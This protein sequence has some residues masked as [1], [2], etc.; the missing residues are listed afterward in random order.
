VNI[1]P[2]HIKTS[3]K[4]LGV[5]AMVKVPAVYAGKNL[6]AHQKIGQSDLLYESKSFANKSGRE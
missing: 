5:S 2:H 3:Y 6:I 1:S 4:G